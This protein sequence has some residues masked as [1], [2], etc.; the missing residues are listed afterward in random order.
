M[1]QNKDV[2]L[3]L[4]ALMAQS[5]SRRTED[6]YITMFFFTT[7]IDE[8]F[9][10]LDNCSDT[11]TECINIPGSYIC[12][13]YKQTYEWDGVTC[14]GKYPFFVWKSSLISLECLVYQG[15]GSF[16]PVLPQNYRLWN[17]AFWG[18]CIRYDEKLNVFEATL[19]GE[20][21]T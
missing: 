14:V 11:V 19:L 17:R 15:V 16:F 6:F 9:Q 8:C 10:E 2:S 5:L 13:C 7:D 20:N 4:L 21:I 18:L 12:S 3:F 1:T